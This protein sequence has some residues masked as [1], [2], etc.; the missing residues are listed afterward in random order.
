MDRY[1]LKVVSCGKNFTSIRK[2]ITSGF[3]AHAAK[4]DPQEGYRT[5]VENQPVYIHPGSSIFH[6]N[7]E[8]VI[9]H[10]LLL[11][12]KEYMRDVITIE[13]KWLVELAPNFYRVHDASHLSKRKRQEKI[14]PLYNKFGDD[15]LQLLKR[16]KR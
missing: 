8:W 14:E 2:A 11:T 7:P 13:P 6:K 9:Y 4:K 5:L 1:K 12:S 3:F 15:P 10:T 16:N